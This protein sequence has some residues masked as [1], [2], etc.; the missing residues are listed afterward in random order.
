MEQLAKT[1]VFYQDEEDRAY[2][3]GFSLGLSLLYYPRLDLITIDM[4]HASAWVINRL[5]F[6]GF[7]MAFK[8]Y[9]RS[10]IPSARKVN[11]ILRYEFQVDKVNMWMHDIDVTARVFPAI[12]KRPSSQ[13]RKKKIAE[14]NKMAETR[15]KKKVSIRK[16]SK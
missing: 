3:Q 1:I 6:Y 2:E 14:I 11:W 13:D 8:T 9:N 16:N 15:K 12:G 7:L 4:S 10:A 5:F